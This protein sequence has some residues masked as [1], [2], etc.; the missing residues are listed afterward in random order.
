MGGWFTDDTPA[1]FRA[2]GWQVIENVDGH[3]PQA[4]SQ[5]ISD[6]RQ[7]SDKPSLICCRTVIGWGSP[8]KQGKESCHGA[9]L[10]DDEIALT[11]DTLQWPHAPFEIP[12]EVRDALVATNRGSA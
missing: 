4:I 5:A 2:Y 1:R 10:G 6:A 8:N 12:D 3:D 7:E 9:P 11:R